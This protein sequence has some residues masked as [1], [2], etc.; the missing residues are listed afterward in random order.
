[1]N[2]FEPGEKIVCVDDFYDARCKEKGV[3]PL[4]K[5]TVYVV[6][7]VYWPTQKEGVRLIGIQNPGDA[8]GEYCYLVTRFR[9]LSE[10]KAEAI[11]KDSRTD[12]V[13]ISQMTTL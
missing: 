2:T 8:W 10:M 11:A 12:T 9:K 4:I 7:S 13:K 5:G 3:C 6:R 1:M